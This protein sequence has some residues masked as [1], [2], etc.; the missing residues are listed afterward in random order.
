MNL[1]YIICG[2]F[3]FSLIFVINDVSSETLEYEVLK[4][5]YGDELVISNSEIWLDG[6][7]LVDGNLSI[8]NS[9]INVNRSID[10]TISEIR[11]NSTGEL[12]IFNSTISA[13]SNDTLSYSMFTI[14]SDAG[15]LIISDTSI[16]YSMV[17][18]VGGDARIENTLLNGHN[19][20]NYGVFSEDTILN[21][22]NVSISNYTL[23]LRSIGTTPVQN[24]VTF[25]NCTSWMT[26]EW[27]VT[28]TAIDTS[29]NGPVTGFQV[30][31]WDSDGT[32]LGTWNWAKE[33]EIDSTGQRNDH[34]A[35]FTAFANFGLAHVDDEWSQSV[36]ENIAFIRYFNLNLSAIEYKSAQ[37]YSS[38]KIW[39][40]GQVVPKWSEINVLVTIDNPTDYNFSNLFLDMD[41]NNN[42]A[43]ARDSISLSPEGETVGNISWKASL[44]GP[45]AL[46]ISTFLDLGSSSNTTISMS[47][48][49]EVGSKDIEEADSGNMLALFVILVIL[50]ACSYIIYSGIEEQDSDSSL[51]GSKLDSNEEVNEDENKREFAIP[52]ESSE[53]E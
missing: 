26:Q 53:E 52:D 4:I 18:L 41:V 15:S 30:R 50:T 49:V 35:N 2:I 20:V 7:I 48:F 42:K 51:S 37:V 44:E 17:W 12:R 24:Q 9:H 40:P 1:G 27:W 10:L 23:G 39:E 19:I 3:I 45:L 22:D 34:L 21:M 5:D 36:T 14:V 28:F 47:K 13:F 46:K 6:D 8:E 16:D 11:I 31:Q 38:G 29:T 32:M 25:S 33:Y 43:F